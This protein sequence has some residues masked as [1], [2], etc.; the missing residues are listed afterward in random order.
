MLVAST[1]PLLGLHQPSPCS[2]PCLS[3]EQQYAALV[4][5]YSHVVQVHLT[6]LYFAL[7]LLRIGTDPGKGRQSNKNGAKKGPILFF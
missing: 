2:S 5:F 1:F 3:S 6:K 4:A 7:L